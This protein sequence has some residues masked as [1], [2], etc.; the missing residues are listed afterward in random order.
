MF[1]TVLHAREGLKT[2]WRYLSNRP[3]T[4]VTRSSS[5]VKRSAD[6]TVTIHRRKKKRT[7][8]PKTSF[9]SKNSW[10]SAS[11]LMMQ[12]RDGGG[13]SNRS[14]K[15]AKHHGTV[16]ANDQKESDGYEDTAWECPEDDSSQDGVV[17]GV[18]DSDRKNTKQ[19]GDDGNTQQRGG[20][21]GRMTWE[22]RYKEL[23]EYKN[24]HAN[25]EVSRTPNSPNPTLGKWVSDQR[26]YY[27][28]YLEGQASSLTDEKV[29]L[30]NLIGFTWRVEKKSPRPRSSLCPPNGG[31]ES[32]SDASVF[33]TF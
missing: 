21:K 19:K 2:R 32:D 16:A 18:D 6:G 24:K 12:A 23:I 10:E 20:S 3:E 17:S 5:S 28:K 29:D 27:K 8:Q 30:L 31:A 15:E 26:E 14:G 22:Y 4:T 33:E 9:M 7:E 11:S 25:C 13:T 1:V